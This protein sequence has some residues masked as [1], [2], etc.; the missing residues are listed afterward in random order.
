MQRVL[1]L[2]VLVSFVAVALFGWGLLGLSFMSQEE[3]KFS[4]SNTIG[5][6]LCLMGGASMALSASRLHRSSELRW[7][8]LVASLGLFCGVA[9]ALLAA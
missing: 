1:V 3:D 6:W 2:R 9:G 7:W 8:T 4:R 5:V